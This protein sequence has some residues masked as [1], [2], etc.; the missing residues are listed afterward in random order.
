[1]QYSTLIPLK[2]K[3]GQKSGLSAYL[4]CYLDFVDVIYVL[5]QIFKL[6]YSWIIT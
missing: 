2:V 1:M 4:P 6:R 5:R 3:I